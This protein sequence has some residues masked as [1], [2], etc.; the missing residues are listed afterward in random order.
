MSSSS[1]C[2]N[3]P[4]DVCDTE[5]CGAHWAPQW[6]R[7]ARE[8]I[9]LADKHVLQDGMNWVIPGKL[10]AGQY[11]GTKS[12]RDPTDNLTTMRV[13]GVKTIIDLTCETDELN[14][15]K[16]LIG[17]TRHNFPI[18][19]ESA[20]NDI[21]VIKAANAAVTAMRVANAGVVYVHCWGGHGRTGVVVSVILGRYLDICADVALYLTSVAHA[22]RPYRSGCGQSASPQSSEQIKQVHKIFK[23]SMVSSAYVSTARRLFAIYNPGWAPPEWVLN[24]MEGPEYLVCAKRSKCYTMDP[25]VQL[26]RKVLTERQPVNIAM[27]LKSYK[28]DRM[29]ATF[30]FGGIMSGYSEIFHNHPKQLPPNI[31]VYC[32]TPI[33]VGEPHELVYR[34]VMNSVGVALDTKDQPDYRMLF[35]GNGQCRWSEISRVI[36]EA[37]ICLLTC[38]KDLSLTKI[39]ICHLGGGCFGQLYK[40]HTGKTGYKAYLEE[41]WLPVVSEVLNE[42]GKFLTE[43]QLLNADFETLKALKI[44]LSLPKCRFYEGGR[45]PDA[46][47]DAD[48]AADVLFQN[49]WDPHSIAGNGN[50]ND[51]SLDGYFGRSSAISVLT[52]PPTNPFIAMIP[53]QIPPSP[54]KVM[55]QTLY[56]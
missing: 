54:S 36:R 50:A 30:G 31:S 37:Y 1:S 14:P 40:S 29:L 9:F 22:T 41:I 47:K 10:I 12:D 5:A 38:A 23:G 2:S 33:N 27:S 53:I 32:Y 19:D 18:V 11:P 52:F 15:Y 51:E 34:H 20:D 24:F 6:A 25:R 4:D 44:K 21:M 17:M 45:I 26:A 35:D 55:L 3:V 42:H 46:M 8:L 48:K 56:L 43:I 16:P 13:Q 28:L 39:S 49:A 7:K